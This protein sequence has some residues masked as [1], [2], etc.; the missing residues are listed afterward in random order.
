LIDI[1]RNPEN[2]AGQATLMVRGMQVTIAVPRHHKAPK[3][4]KPVTLNVLLVE[5]AS[6]PTEGKPIRWLLLTTLTIE[7]FEQAW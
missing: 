1:E 2:P 4:Y 6:A 3:Q 7:S 5:A